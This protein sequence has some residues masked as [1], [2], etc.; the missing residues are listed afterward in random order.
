MNTN[1]YTLD[2]LQAQIKREQKKYAKAIK[3]E[4]DFVIAKQIHIKIIELKK[5]ID[6]RLK[7]EVGED[8]I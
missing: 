2:D 1:L 3:T 4:Q 6:D 5:A 8:G 7:N